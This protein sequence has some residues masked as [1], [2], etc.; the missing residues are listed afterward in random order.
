M[1]QDVLPTPHAL[2]NTAEESAEAIPR[3]D[4]APPWKLVWWKFRKHRLAMISLVVLILIYLVVLFGEFVAPYNAGTKHGDYVHAPPQQIHLFD[5]GR[6]APF[7]HPYDNE[8]D[9]ITYERTF[10]VNTERK[11]RLG[12]F[13][14]GDEYE[15][16]GLVKWDVHL[17]GTTSTED[18]FFLLGSD[19]LGRDVYSRILH[20]TRVSMTIGLVGVFISLVLGIVL[21]GLSGLIGGVVDNVIQRIIEIILSIPDIPLLLGL[22]AAVPTD[23]SPLR[24]YFGITIILSLRGWTWMARQVRGRFL[25]LREEDFVLAAELDGASRMRV[26][27]RH[28][29]PSFMS[30]IIASVTLAVPGMILAETA[31]SFLGLGLKRPVVSWGVM[32]Q[33]AQSVTVISNFPWMLAPGM[34]VV[35]AVLALNFLGDGLRD[36]ADPYH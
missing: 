24:V 20:S 2:P 34:A 8:V 11:A 3:V 36:A 18:P 30:H 9:P 19:S 15:W 12:F 14:K 22:A 1:S 27:N 5:D 7:V 25:S 6:F 13:V 32:L 31:L 4:M 21:G 33:D 26:I 17:F 29:I 23:W 28:M 35:I 10:T 16:L